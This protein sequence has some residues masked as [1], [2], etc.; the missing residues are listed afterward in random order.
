MFIASN[1]FDF[2][3]ELEAAW[4]DIRAEY[5]R[6]PGDSFDPWV[7]REMHGHGWSIYGLYAAGQVIPESLKLCPK[8][9]A[10][11]QRIPGLSMAGF[12]RL[13]GGAHIVPHR[14]WAVSVFRMHLGLVIPDGCRMRV[15]DETKAW[16]EGRCLV[17]DDTVEHEAWNDSSAPRGVLLL[18]FLRP[19][20]SGGAQ[21]H[22]PE[23]VRQYVERLF[24]E[25]NK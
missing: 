16:Q 17:F 1:Q 13:A 15:G 3:P 14:G 10:A 6:L 11:L 24:R 19:G 12:S 5:L 18:D 7:Q 21:D 4:T 20:V 25:R 22:V 2:I 9:C 8:T 23:E